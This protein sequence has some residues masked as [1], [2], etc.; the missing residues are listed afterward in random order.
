M[1]LSLFDWFG[2]IEP[3]LPYCGIVNVPLLFKILCTQ[4][5]LFRY[6]GN[7]ER[8]YST[9]LLY[10]VD[11]GFFVGAGNPRIG[12]LF[13]SEAKKDRDWISRTSIDAIL[14]ES[15]LFWMHHST[16]V[17]STKSS[18]SGRFCSERTDGGVDRFVPNGPGRSCAD[19]QRVA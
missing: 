12:P 2:T 10:P 5:P 19:E 13:R 6:T 17:L 18:S 15:S 4:S 9:A 3:K 8:C 1:Y 14:L 11:R 16:S 7:A